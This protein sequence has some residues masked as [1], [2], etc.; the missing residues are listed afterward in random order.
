FPRSGRRSRRSWRPCSVVPESPARSC[1]G[2]LDC[3]SL[4]GRCQSARSFSL[5][6]RSGYI[7]ATAHMRVNHWLELELGSLFRR[8]GQVGEGRPVLAFVGEILT[9]LLASEVAVCNRAGEGLPGTKIN[10]PEHH[11]ADVSG[12]EGLAVRAEG[13]AINVALLQGER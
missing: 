7:Q 11:P 4:N 1:R 13:H 3:Y 6:G 8:N 12:R 5:P 2:S 10:V 9:P